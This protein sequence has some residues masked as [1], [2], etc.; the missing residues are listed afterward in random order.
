[1]SKEDVVLVVEALEF[2][3][4][5]QQFHYNHGNSEEEYNGYHTIARDIPR[6]LCSNFV[7]FARLGNKNLTLKCV[8]E[9]LKNL[10]DSGLISY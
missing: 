9:L 8:E 3:E 1:M 10:T 2:S 7:Y 4:E 5:Q 6:T